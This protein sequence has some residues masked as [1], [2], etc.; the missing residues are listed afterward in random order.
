M[1]LILLSLVFLGNLEAQDMVPKAHDVE[2]RVYLIN[3]EDVIR[4]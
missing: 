4:V 3:I 1:A 2:I